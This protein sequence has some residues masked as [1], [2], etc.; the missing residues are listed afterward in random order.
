MDLKCQVMMNSNTS[1]VSAKTLRNRRKRKARADRY[2]KAMASCPPPPVKTPKNRRPRRARGSKVA[3]EVD[4]IVG[5]LDSGAMTFPQ[6]IATMPE[7]R[8]WKDGRINI[9]LDDLSWFFKYLDPA[10]ATESGRS[11][12]EYG[13]IPDGLVKFSVDAEIRTVNVEKCPGL[14]NSTI[15]LDGSLWSLSILSFPT[16][17]LGYIAI[18]NTDDE[19]LNDT[20][21]SQL[22]VFI[23][24]IVNWRYYVD[25][26][27]W[28][29]F[30]PNSNWFFRFRI[31][32]PTYDLPDVGE[33]LVRTVTDYRLT[34]KGITMEANMP[35]L[36][37]QGYWIGGHYAITPRVT[38]S[39]PGD[40][41][42]LTVPMELTRFD[43]QGAVAW[44]GVL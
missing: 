30:I 35:T 12:G 13:K 17:R 14:G 40:G 8:A 6:N 25:D 5:D 34:Y 28:V 9:E 27:N 20:V 7:L 4:D 1:G 39:D 42:G 36:V 41:D 15:P 10:G 11:V 43:T 23:N 38:T 44:A 3:S 32:P 16:F 31:L 22:L 19:E 24:N 33:G 2:R 26:V 21:I 18:A 37:D 29:N